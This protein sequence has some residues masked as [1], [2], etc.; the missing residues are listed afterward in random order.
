MG[1]VGGAL[2]RGA[3]VVIYPF[4]SRGKILRVFQIGT[5]GTK[6]TRIVSRVEGCGGSSIA[7][8]SVTT[9]VGCT[10]LGLVSGGNAR[11]IVLAS[12]HRDRGLK[13]ATEL[14]RRVRR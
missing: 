9:T 5:G 14:V 6:G 8:A 12:N 1:S 4:R 2:G 7:C 13:K 11:V 10:H 3:R